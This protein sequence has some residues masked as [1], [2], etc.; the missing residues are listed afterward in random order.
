MKK[1]LTFIL[2][3]SVTLSFGQSSNSKSRLLLNHLS[4]KTVDTSYV[5]EKT[6]SP[7]TAYAS[8]GLSMS[9]TSNFRAGSYF[10]L[11]GGVCKENLCL[12]VVV[13]RGNITG[14]FKNTDAIN[15]YYYEPKVTVTFPLGKLTGTAI[16]GVGGY[17]GTSH[18]L[19][20][21][22]SGVYYQ[23]DNI[24]YGLLYSNW[25]GVDYITPNITYNF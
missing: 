10:N 1:I 2:L 4:S 24:S 20:E 25:D 6:K 11:E 16:F 21:Y 14:M 17:F 5:K 7:I 23:I 18:T 15:N 19:I 8:V 12:G 13:G 3:L 9:N 22:G